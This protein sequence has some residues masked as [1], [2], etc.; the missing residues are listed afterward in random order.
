MALEP[1][2]TSVKE[3]DGNLA[4]APYTRSEDVCLDERAGHGSV[5]GSELTQFVSSRGK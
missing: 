3:N 2:K 5:V 4:N 1:A